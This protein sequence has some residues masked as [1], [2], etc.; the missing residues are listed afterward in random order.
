MLLHENIDMDAPL[1]IDKFDLLRP[2][3]KLKALSSDQRVQPFQIWGASD[4]PYLVAV[5]DV[6]DRQKIKVSLNHRIA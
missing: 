3:G 1:S 5:R 4:F 2:T 6:D